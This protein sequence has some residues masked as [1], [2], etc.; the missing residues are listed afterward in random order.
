MAVWASRRL[1]MRQAD[2]S[3]A[4][5]VSI[6]DSV[7]L[8][9]QKTLYRI[10]ENWKTM[11]NAWTSGL[12]RPMVSQ[13]PTIDAQD[14]LFIEES[15]VRVWMHN[16]VLVG[17]E[18]SGLG[19]FAYDL[20]SGAPIERRARDPV[21]WA[22]LAAQEDAEPSEGHPYTGVFAVYTALD[23]NT[24]PG[25]SIEYVP[26]E[27]PTFVSTRAV[28]HVLRDL[29]SRKARNGYRPPRWQDLLR[30]QYPIQCEPGQGWS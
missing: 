10:Q 27:N 20:V 18:G 2:M 11:N 5:D 12:G 6:C 3:E 1:V 17:M 28:R 29:A 22:E 7:L 14:F 21:N 16:L 13:N 30:T 15:I 26:A 8:L 9:S 24:A 4:A 23:R 25:G 19:A